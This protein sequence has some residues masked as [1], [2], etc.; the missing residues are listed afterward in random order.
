[1]AASSLKTGSNIFTGKTYE[2]TP[3]SYDPTKYTG[4]SAYGGYSSPLLGQAKQTLSQQMTGQ[5][6]PYQQ[7]ILDLQLKK[8]LAS[9]REGSYGM[10]IGAQ[11]GIEAQQAGES[12]LGAAE[13]AGKQQQ[14]AVGQ[15]LG[16]E[17]LGQQGAEFG[18][19]Q[20]AAETARQN[21]FAQAE[22][23]Y[24]QTF[25]EQQ[26]QLAQQYQQM[27]GQGG[28]FGAFNALGGQVLGSLG[29]RLGGE[30]SNQVFGN[31][32]ESQLN[33]YKKYGML[34]QTQQSQFNVPQDINQMY[35]PSS[36]WPSHKPTGMPGTTFY[37]EWPMTK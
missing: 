32:M 36:F 28:L 4:M 26:Q 37:N 22:N 16:Y 20:L 23:Q 15:S 21:A 14:W 12:A 3:G 27:S 1:M 9:T 11:K 33:L 31:P 2:Y 29:G 34:G 24:G 5:L 13:L 35:T 10:P 7:Q 18:Y 30:I 19:G 25:N 17:Q 6:S 8:G